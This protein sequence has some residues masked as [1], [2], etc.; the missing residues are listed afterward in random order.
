ME[1][2]KSNKQ[3]SQPCSFSSLISDDELSS[4]L[5]ISSIEEA[6]NNQN[7]ELRKVEYIKHEIGNKNIDM[8]PYTTDSDSNLKQD[9]RTQSNQFRMP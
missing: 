9:Q 2:R 3:P 7:V 1:N 4:L 5:I 8:S 6:L